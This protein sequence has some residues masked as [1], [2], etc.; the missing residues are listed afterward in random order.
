MGGISLIG[1]LKS[2]CQTCVLLFFCHFLHRFLFLFF[3][4][5]FL[6]PSTMEQNNHNTTTA[7]GFKPFLRSVCVTAAWCRVLP[8]SFFPL[9]LLLLLLNAV[10]HTSH[11]TYAK[12]ISSSLL[13]S[14]IFLIHSNCGSFIQANKTV[15]AA[16]LCGKH[17]TITT[18]C[19]EGDRGEIINNSSPTHKRGR[20][21]KKEKKKR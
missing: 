2:C 4:F 1:F 18:P 10:R 8:P 14:A 3:L 6:M 12:F 19:A 21:R 5:L 11:T 9:L 17:H 20:E 15:R 16:L 13:M 7:L